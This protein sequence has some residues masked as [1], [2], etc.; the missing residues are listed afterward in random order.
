MN[1]Q[2]GKG[3]DVAS[4]ARQ[5]VPCEIPAFCRNNYY[6]G[7]L[8]TERDFTDEQRYAID[9]MRLHNSALHGWGVVCGLEVKPHSICPDLRVVVTSGLAIDDCGRDIRVLTDVQLELPKDTT[10]PPPK[11]HCP[12]DPVHQGEGGYGEKKEGPQGKDLYICLSYCESETEFMPAP[13]DECGCNSTGQ[14]PGRVCEQY[15]LV[16]VE[17]EPAEIKHVREHMDCRSDNC[18]EIYERLLRY[19]S[20]AGQVCCMPIAVIRGWVPGEIVKHGMIDNSIR[21]ML[22]STHAL[23]LMIRCILE[24]L[25]KPPCLTRI[26]HLNWTHAEEYHCHDFIRFFVGTNDAPQALEIQFEGKVR[27]E[28]INARTF[29]AMVV[30]RPHEPAEP[31]RVEIAPGRVTPSPDGTKCMLYIDPAYARKALD[32]RSFDLFITLNAMW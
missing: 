10:P 9:K 29:Q 5:C 32:G 15:K 2:T 19:C 7:K 28:G 16:I 18:L 13:F 26:I 22:P 30:H 1:T 24:R 27:P 25:P 21:P 3:Q 12:P 17:E 20:K 23:D 6:T 8:L 14:K 4:T 11:T 31:R